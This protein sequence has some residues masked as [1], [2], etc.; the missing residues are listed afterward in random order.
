MITLEEVDA[1]DL[2]S[3]AAFSF[4]PPER[5]LVTQAYDL[6][7]Q[8]LVEQWHQR[9][10]D[11]PSF[12]RGFVW[13]DVRA[14]RLIES[15]L[16]NIPIP[17]LYLAETDDAKW[18]VIDGQQR[19]RSVVRFVDGDF[20]LK[21]LGILGDLN[22]CF[23]DNLPARER[24]YLMTRTMR[25][26]VL[27]PE[28][29]P[30]I[31]FEVFERLNTGSIALNAQEV[32]NSLFRGP[33]VDLLHDLADAPALRQLIG[34][35]KPRPRMVDEELILRFFALRDAIVTY[36]P[37]LLRVLNEFAMANRHAGKRRIAEL[38]NLFVASAEAVADLLGTLAFRRFTRDG[39][40]LERAPNR[41]LFDA[42][43]L[44]A[45]WLNTSDLPLFRP[46]LVESLASLFESDEV[47][48]DSIRRATA[49]RTRTLY[50]LH[51]V[52]AAFRK[53]GLTV[54]PPPISEG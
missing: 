43:M 8:T 30:N 41:A 39:R 50:R 6:S 11:V 37:P 49:D 2:D 48:L 47:F 20:S 32:R 13:D 34:G 3:E 35:T 21:G 7:I 9:G 12:Q 24:R 23:Y 4:P 51:G 42:Q 40:L 14:S 36:Q 28:S 15:L 1:G 45:S 44:A 16:V 31:K 25:A 52:V 18:E 54:E 17:V 22:G 46:A 33:F 19:I 26:V 29:H 5:K 53:A 27:A 10:I 38:R